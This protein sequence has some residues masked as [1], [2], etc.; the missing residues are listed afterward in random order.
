MI[1]NLKVFF[2]L[3][4]INIKVTLTYRASLFISLMLNIFW[5][6]SYIIFLEVIFR[7]VSTLGGLT[8]GET[9]LI[10]AFFYLFTNIS[11]IFYRDSFEQFSEKMR[12]GNIDTW[13]TKP[14]SS[15][16]LMFMSTMRFDYLSAFA[17]TIAIFIYAYQSLHTAPHI[18]FLIAGIGIS[19]I[20][21][22]IF[23]SL[24]S[25]LATMSFWLEKNN[26]LNMMAWQL[27]QVGRY[28]REIYTSWAKIIFTYMIP[29]SLIAN[30]PAEITAGLATGKSLFIFTGVTAAIYIVSLLFWRKGLTKYSSAG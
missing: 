3:I 9:L 30:I 14:A 28:P 10:L 7:N 15:R 19:L 18:G 1:H 21:H 29:L 5:V 26:N 20:S 4:S 2:T 22:I 23:F 8:K 25:I 16:L 11:D 17:V 27:T 13:L 12:T 24:L 6:T